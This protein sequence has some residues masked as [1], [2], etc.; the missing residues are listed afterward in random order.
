M[1]NGWKI[2]TTH[3]VT[4]WADNAVNSNGYNESYF[5]YGYAAGPNASSSNWAVTREASVP[6]PGSLAL[7]GLALAGAAVVRARKAWAV[8]RP[9]A[10]R[11]PSSLVQAALAGA[12]LLAVRRRVR[13]CLEPDREQH[14]SPHRDDLLVARPSA[15]RPDRKAC[16]HDTTRA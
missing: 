13:R 14:G 4:P 6:E 1:V 7:V 3:G 11:H 12:L 10:R 2:D 15:R 16:N 8:G 5:S 9:D